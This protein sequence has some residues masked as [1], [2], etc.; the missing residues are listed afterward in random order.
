M[1]SLLVSG[2]INVYIYKPF[3]YSVHVLCQQFLIYLL[4]R[5]FIESDHTQ[6]LSLRPPEVCQTALQCGNCA[7][8]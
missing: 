8:R 1:L 3:P 5:M 7:Y 2:E 4:N 6:D